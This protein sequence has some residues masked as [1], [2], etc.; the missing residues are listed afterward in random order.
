[1][2]LLP[3]LAAGVTHRN[4]AR[5]FLRSKV[6]FVGDVRR[7]T[8]RERSIK[9]TCSI[10]AES[11][12]LEV[13]TVGLSC[14]LLIAGTMQQMA[15]IAIPTPL[16]LPTL[17]FSTL[18]RTRSLHIALR[19][20]LLSLSRIWDPFFS[21]PSSR[22]LPPR[23]FDPTSRDSMCSISSRRQAC[24]LAPTRM[25]GFHPDHYSR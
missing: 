2:Q 13:S 23:R 24:H 25:L 21:H 14:R 22:E 6:V 15:L 3:G 1:M 12:W 4:R 16:G 5:G 19:F 8:K 10:A 17:E 7:G 9:R 18:P 20:S 11:P